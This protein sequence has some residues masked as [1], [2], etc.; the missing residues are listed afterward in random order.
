MH[1]FS[2]PPLFLFFVFNK[3]PEAPEYGSGKIFYP[4]VKS[5]IALSDVQKNPLSFAI[6]RWHQTGSFS[7]R[8][9]RGSTRHINLFAETTLSTGD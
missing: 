3:F 9:M 7:D 4:R 1:P 2:C 6:I 8:N 5:Q